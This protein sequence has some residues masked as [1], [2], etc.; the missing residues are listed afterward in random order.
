MGEFHDS[1]TE[2][3]NP[4]YQHPAA[5]PPGVV[6]DSVCY[7]SCSD[8]LVP[9]NSNLSYIVVGANNGSSTCSMNYTLTA[10]APGD[11]GKPFYLLLSP[12]IEVST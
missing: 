12:D 8:L 10:H 9:L 5:A 2:G 3:K 7:G 1:F 6:L 11:S 4:V